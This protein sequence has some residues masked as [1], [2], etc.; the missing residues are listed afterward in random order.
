MWGGEEEGSSFPH[1]SIL[2]LLFEILEKKVVTI[3][4]LIFKLVVKILVA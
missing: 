1:S 3:V 4:S 2:P